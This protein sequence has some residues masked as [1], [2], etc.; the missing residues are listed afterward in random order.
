VVL[1]SPSNTADS[2]TGLDDQ[3]LYFRTA[4]PDVLQAN[5]LADIIAR[6]GTRSLAIIHRDDTYGVGLAQSTK[7]RLVEAGLRAESITLTSY[8]VLPNP[9]TDFTEIGQAVRA[10]NPDGVLIISFAEAEF[11]VDALVRAGITS[12]SN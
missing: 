4:P 9:P 11:I 2:L 12:I 8:P 7:D 1:F 3:G 5:A 6:D 10:Q